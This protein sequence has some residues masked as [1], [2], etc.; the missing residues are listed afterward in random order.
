MTGIDLL[1]AA[2]IALLIGTLLTAVIAHSR[3]LCGYV[4]FAAV[5]AATLFIIQLA[6][7]VLL[8]GPVVADEP[9]FTVP[10]F[11]AKLKFQVNELSIIFMLITVILGSCATLFSIRYM[12]V[13]TQYRLARYYPILLLFFASILALLATK[14]MLLFLGFWEIMALTSWLLVAFETEDPEASRSALI[15]F[16][17][18]HVATGLMI[19]A[20]MIIYPYTEPHSFELVD[21]REGLRSMIETQPGMVGLAVAL[22][23]TAAATKAGILPFGFWL[24]HAHPVAPSPFSAVLSGCMV[25]MG[26]Y[27]CLLVLMQLLPISSFSVISGSIVAVLGTVSIVVGT[28]T[29][30]RQNDSKR[31]LAFST[32]GQ[33]GYIWLAIGVGVAFL[34]TNPYISVLALTAS[35]FHTINHAGFKSL[36]F[37][38]AGAALYRTGTRDM[39][40]AGGLIQIMPITGATA[41]IGALS[42]SGVPGFSGFTSKWLIVE[43]SIVGGWHMPLM[44]FLGLIAIFISAATLATL[45]KFIGGIFLGRLQVGPH[46]ER[47][48]VPPTMVIAQV[49]LA[50]FCIVFGL[51]PM[52]A[53]RYMYTA[54]A[55]ALPPDFATPSFSTM[56]GESMFNLTLGTEAAPS[57]GAWDPVVILLVFAGCV[58]LAVLI[59]RI[60][61]GARRSVPVW[62]CGEHHEFAE[63]RYPSH[64]FM[65]PFTRVV[66]WM[67]PP[68]GLKPLTVPRGLLRRLGIE[69]LPESPPGDVGGEPPSDADATGTVEPTPEPAGVSE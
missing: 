4:A 64:S 23:V 21:L 37:L 28:L 24:P 52:Y 65:R 54:V 41:I 9:L 59:A 67:Y 16:I 20:L 56:F 6:I 35:L 30:M 48:E 5:F 34:P 44:V 27:R 12:L 15:Y 49:V 26:V 46:V 32:I 45:I 68:I 13:Y 69:P 38:N 50:L 29:A 36:L 33:M 11:H 61:G 1:L 43:S 57:T 42:I 62:L 60:G 17:V 2:L 66:E 10:Y 55:G 25:K 19:F 63:Y 47:R 40:K 53:I 39:E 3:T 14:N 8:G 51:L 31:L 58:L 22:F 7:E 18:S